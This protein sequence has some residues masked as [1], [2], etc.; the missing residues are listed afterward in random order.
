MTKTLVAALALTT[1]SMAAFAES[2]AASGPLDQRATAPTM[3]RAAVVQELMAARAAG[4][5]LRAGELG[6]VP[7]AFVPEESRAEV[8][9]EVLAARAAGTLLRAGELGQVPPDF[10][11]E[12]SRAEVRADV[13]GRRG[14]PALGLQPA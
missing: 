8:R 7:P 6:Q 12:K 11:S 1:A 2:P 10:M 4:T 9:N 3:T 5:L 14:P 13:L